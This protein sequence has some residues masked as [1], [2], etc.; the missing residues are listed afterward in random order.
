MSQLTHGWIG[1]AV[2]FY[3]LLIL[4]H[5]LVLSAVAFLEARNT[6]QRQS[7][8]D[9]LSLFEGDLAPPV[10]VLVPAYNEELTIVDSVRSLMQLQYPSFEIIV[11]NDGSTDGTLERLRQAFGLQRSYR[12]L[13]ARVPRERVRGVYSSPDFPFLVVLD[14]ENGGKAM[15]LNIALAFSRHPLFCAIDAD[16]VLERETLL[17]LALP[18]YHDR[19]RLVTGGVVR[20]ANGSVIRG[21][22]VLLTH[23]PAG[24][25]ARFQTVEYLRGMLAGRMGWSYFDSLFIVSGALGMFS[26]EAVLAVG[27]YRTDT[28]GEDMELVMRLQSWAARKGHRRAVEFVAPA[29]A[30]TE[31]PENLRALSRQRARWHQG[32]AESLWLN[33]NILFRDY[34]NFAH[35]L[36]YLSQVAIELLGPALELIGFAIFIALLLTGHADTTFSVLYFGCFVAGGTFASLLGIA[37]ETVVCPRYHRTRDILGLILYAVLEN[38]GYRQLTAAWRVTGLWRAITRQRRWDSPPRRG[39]RSEPEAESEPTRRAA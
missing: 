32:L 29:V 6:L 11:V 13:R 4:A 26:R 17:R 23:L 28:L 15:G 37:L 24:H 25:L 7:I 36:A 39:H 33:R 12:T 27:G 2:L 10:S 3:S 9:R 34:F 16:S 38:F 5:Y 1:A 20:P 31:V 19:S 22:T 8:S 14:L 35:G 21:G 18:F 30:W